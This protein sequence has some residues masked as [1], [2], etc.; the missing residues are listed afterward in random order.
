MSVSCSPLTC[1]SLLPY[2]CPVNG[3]VSW[4]AGEHS[5]LSTLSLSLFLWWLSIFTGLS[6]PACAKQNKL[7]LVIWANHY[8]QQMLNPNCAAGWK[9][10]RC[11]TGSSPLQSSPALTYGVQSIT[12]V[13]TKQSILVSLFLDRWGVTARNSQ[14]QKHRDSQIL[15]ELLGYT[16]R[17]SGALPP[18]PVCFLV[19]KEKGN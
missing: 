2:W 11:R 7:F 13:N 4:E 3:A 9:S 14:L 6:I 5:I 12:S 10:L 1:N 15:V 17:R 19:N 8:E 18:Q 16:I